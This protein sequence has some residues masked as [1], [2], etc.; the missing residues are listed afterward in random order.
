[1]GSTTTAY[2]GYG[3]NGEYITFDSGVTFNSLVLTACAPDCAWNADSV[4]VSLFDTSNTI[5]GSQTWFSGPQQTLNFDSAN[6]SKVLF[7]FTGGID[8]Y[9]DGRLAAWY[10]VSDITYTTGISPIPEPETYALLLVGL[11]LLGFEARRRRK[12]ELA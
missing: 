1:L 3:G 11:S 9:G 6:T 12:L 5:L 8:A 4:T 10:F 2:N 7:D